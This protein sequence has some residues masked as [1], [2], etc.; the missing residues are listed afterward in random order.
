MEKL[1]HRDFKKALF[2]ELIAFDI[3]MKMSVED[4]IKFE[5][6][7]ESVFKTMLEKNKIPKPSKRYRSVMAE[8]TKSLDFKIRHLRALK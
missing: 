3:G 8:S 5:R 4:L 1:N 2:T 7:I 6:R